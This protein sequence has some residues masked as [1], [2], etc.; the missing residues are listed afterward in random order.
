VKKSTYILSL[1]TLLCAPSWA[2][3]SNVASEVSPKLKKF[4]SDNPQVAKLFT[5]TIS[6]VSSNRT[7]Q[8][9]YFYSDNESEARSFH[10]YPNTTGF[11]DVMLCV[12]ENQTPLDEFIT[13]FFEIQNSKGEN[14]FQNLE[15]E[16]YYGTISRERFAKEILQNEFQATTNVRSTLLSLRLPTNDI[17]NSDYYQSFKECPTNFEGF[18]KY[19]KKASPDRDVV[20]EYESKY[21]SLR[22]MYLDSNSPSNSVAPKN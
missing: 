12:R 6:T 3:S 17:V 8:I 21:D 22:K 18:L 20:K 9:F 10:F 16:A 11:P 4:L 1:L 7:I 19:S 13:V 2:Q 15:Q 14:Y 5:N